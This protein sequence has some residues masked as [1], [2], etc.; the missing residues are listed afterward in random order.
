MAAGPALAW[1]VHDRL[2]IACHRTFLFAILAIIGAVMFP[3]AA[4][5]GYSD[6]LTSRHSP[7]PLVSPPD[8]GGILAVKRD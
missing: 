6:R 3:S 2:R 5:R 8:G 1:P 7:V 4:T